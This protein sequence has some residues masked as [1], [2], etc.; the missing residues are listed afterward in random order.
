MSPF[1]SNEKIVIMDKIFKFYDLNHDGVI[2]I[3]ELLQAQASIPWDT[4]FSQ[5]IGSIIDI[6]VNDVLLAKR[7][8]IIFDINSS[9]FEMFLKTSWIASEIISKIFKRSTKGWPT[10]TLKSIFTRSFEF[11]EQ[12]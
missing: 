12:E 7:R 10:I 11:T 1:L 3:V 2:S 4:Q 6:Y 9:T 5:E 8:R